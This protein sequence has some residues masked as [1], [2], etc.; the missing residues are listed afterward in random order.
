MAKDD[1]DFLVF[2]ILT[3]L[4]AC[5]RRRCH[6]EITAFMKRVISPEV[7][8]DY[9]VDVLRF[10]TREELID[11]LTFVKAWGNDYTLTNDYSDMKI[12][13]QG[14]RYLLDND[15][16]SV[17]GVKNGVDLS[18]A[19]RDY[20]GILKRAGLEA[21]QK[22][23]YEPIAETQHCKWKAVQGVVRRAAKLAWEVNP[24]AV[25]VMAVYPLTGCP[26][27]VQFLEMVYN[28]VVRG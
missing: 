8:E 17:P 15:K 12:T 23:I 18:H 5:F 14:I 7:S 2:R 24:D 3:Y 11:G 6:F 21:V 13:P 19:Y 16:G 4:Y 20:P 26:S 1:Y 9:L 27:A 10:M 22:E 28:A 25:R